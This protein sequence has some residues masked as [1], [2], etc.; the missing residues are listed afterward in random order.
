MQQMTSSLSLQL[1]HRHGDDCESAIINKNNPTA[2]TRT[3]CHLDVVPARLY[4]F[5]CPELTR[6]QATWDT[7][8]GIDA[9]WCRFTDRYRSIGQAFLSP[10]TG[11]KGDCF[12]DGNIQLGSKEAW[13]IN[14]CAT[15][16]NYSHAP[17]Q[18]SKSIQEE[19]PP[20]HHCPLT[21][22]QLS[23][24]IC[25]RQPYQGPSTSVES[26]LPNVFKNRES[27]N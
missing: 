20:M 8:E 27:H 19:S 14:N 1:P 18:S 13:F 15:E 6:P 24:Q 5:S 22:H 7:S 10:A 16:T 11:P 9:I 23:S 25:P 21:W 3:T 26:H 4:F 12:P 17:T 2:H